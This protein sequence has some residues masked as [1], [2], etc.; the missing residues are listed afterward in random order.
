MS[1][2]R[3]GVI[4]VLH[5]SGA[6]IQLTQ[7]ARLPICS[8]HSRVSTLNV[9]ISSSITSFPSHVAISLKRFQS[10]LFNTKRARMKT[11]EQRID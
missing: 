5:A 7:N 2:A 10:G 6:M 9:A 8:T 1:V 11:K 3:K 4:F